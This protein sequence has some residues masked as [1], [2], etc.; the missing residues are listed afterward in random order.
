MSQR[1]F[2]EQLTEQQARDG[3]SPSVVRIEGRGDDRTL[4]LPGDEYLSAREARRLATWIL[5]R[6]KRA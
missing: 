3:C 4:R 2:I 5:S 6:F 1:V